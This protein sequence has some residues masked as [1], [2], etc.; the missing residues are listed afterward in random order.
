MKEKYVFLELSY[1]IDDPTDV[2]N[3]ISGSSV[4]SKS[5]LNLWKFSI[6]ALLKPSLEN[7][8]ITLLAWTVNFQ[9][10][11]LDLEKAEK[12]EIK[13]PT[14]V[15]SSIKKEFQENIYFC[16][17]DYTKVF[18]CVDHNELWKILKEMGIPDYLTCLLRNLYA[19]QEATVRTRHWP[20]DWFQIGKI[21]LQ[22]CILS[23]Y[24][25][26]LYA[27]CI[28][29]NVGLNEAQAGIK[30]ARCNINNL[31]YADDTTLNAESEEE[32][33]SILMKVKE[34]SEKLA[35]TQHSEKEDHGIQ[36]Y[37]FMVYR[38]EIVETVTD[39]IFLGSK[40]TMD[41]DSSHEIKR[42]FLLGR[43]VMKN[44]DSML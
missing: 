2:G 25:F 10:F 29:W 27:E 23:T 4:F 11:K 41:T 12:P 17:M 19:G 15:G 18:N 5:S 14:S 26:N 40:I 31:R 1:F 39:F 34:E 7:L 3:L 6:H 38:R 20:T 33:R 24:S 43:K 32:L 9:M 28:I 16:F 13:L 37:H 35:Y 21:V 44:L 42:C 30:I 8:S 36:S 22:G